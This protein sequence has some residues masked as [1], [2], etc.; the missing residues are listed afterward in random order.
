MPKKFALAL[1]LKDDANLIAE[2]ERYHRQIPEPIHE[3]LTR[4]GILSM[5]IYRWQN[6]LFMI[7]VTTDTFSLDE[8]MA[9]DK[10]NPDVQAWE[11]LMWRFQ[12]PLPGTKPGEK[13]QLM[14]CIFELNA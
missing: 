14:S 8:K 7:M 1:D 13:W 4:A 6:R 10:D 12:Q 2:Y 11:K 5:E 3:S 9:K